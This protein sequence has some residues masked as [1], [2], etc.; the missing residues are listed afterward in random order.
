MIGAILLAAGRSERFGSN[1]LQEKL[2]G[3]PVWLQSFLALS[4]HPEI[5]FVGIVCSEDLIPDVSDC[6]ARFVVVGGA[7]RQ[8]SCFR[9]LKALP[10]DC[11]I[12]LI[13]DA[14][15]PWVSA[16]VIS[17]VIAGVKENGAAFPYVPV[18]DT[19]KQ[20]SDGQVV[21]LKRS[22]LAA[23]QTPQG[24]RVDLILRAHESASGEAT[25]DMALIEEFGHSPLPVLGDLA[26]KKVTYQGDLSVQLEFRTGLGYDIH[27]FSDDPNRPMWLGGI[28]FDSRPGLDGHSDADALIHAVV[29]AILGAAG[30][31]DI[32]LIFSNTDPRWKDCP[33]VHFL[34]HAAQVAG[35]AGWTIRHIDA[36]VV[37][38]RPKVMKRREEI[39]AALAAA[40]GIRPDQVSVKATTNEGLGAI[41]RSEGA[42]AFAVATLS[43]PMPS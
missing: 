26:N 39:C 18:T 33:S 13:H 7:S 28:E 3:K 5:D 31:G 12:V 20:V 8:E 42:A 37:A 19:I 1:K 24:A 10:A 6:G 22:E 25:D 4:G 36:S 35:E 30:L 15:R 40:A 41:G 38:E 34:K 11:E 43:R 17:R 2:D 29:D 14:A 27:R 32:G 23:V 9:G 16:D 21:T